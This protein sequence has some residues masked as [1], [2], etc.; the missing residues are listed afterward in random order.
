M[1]V[2]KSI[3]ADLIKQLQVLARCEMCPVDEDDFN[4]SDIFGGNFDDC[5]WG[6][7]AD[8]RVALAREILEKI[9]VEW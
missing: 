6:G 1:A 2:G 5:Y 3:D 7:R 9:G 4:P 8:G